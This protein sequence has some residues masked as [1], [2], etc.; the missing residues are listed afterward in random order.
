MATKIVRIEANP[1][2][3]RL[4]CHANVQTISAKDWSGGRRILIDRCAFRTWITGQCSRRFIDCGHLAT[5][6][7]RTA[8]A[9]AFS[10][11]RA[12][13]GLEISGNQARAFVEG[14]VRPCPL[15]QNHQP[16][17]KPDQENDVNKKPD[18]PRG[19]AT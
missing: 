6:K 5:S 14:E 12:R 19:K 8:P 13:F 4:L 15:H 7:Q 2:L 10:C 17:P 1:D 16:I 9:V 3:G 18:Q 11:R